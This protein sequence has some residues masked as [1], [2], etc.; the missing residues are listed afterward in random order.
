MSRF[1][2]NMFWILVP[3]DSDANWEHARMP[4]LTEALRV[5]YMSFCID[6]WHP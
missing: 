2:V 1:T 5:R 3:S 6:V 4:E